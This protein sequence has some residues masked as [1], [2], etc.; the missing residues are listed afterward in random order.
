MKRVTENFAEGQWVIRRNITHG[1][2]EYKTRVGGWTDVPARAWKFDTE[3][4]AKF[5]L[6]GN[7]GEVVQLV[8]HGPQLYQPLPPSRRLSDAER[9]DLADCERLVQAGLEASREARARLLHIRDA[10]LYRQDFATFE[11]YMEKRWGYSA[12][13]G[14]R[15][16]DWSEVEKNLLSEK[17]GADAAE[18][19][20][21]P[22][23][24]RSESQARPLAGLKPAEAQEVWKE[25]VKSAPGGQVTARH[26]QAAVDRHEG[27]TQPSDLKPRSGAWP[28]PNVNGVYSDKLATKLRWS[29]ANVGVCI[30]LLQLGPDQWIQAVESH[31]NCGSMGGHQSPLM[32]KETFPGKPEA[33]LAAVAE[34]TD[35]MTQTIK[36]GVGTK[37]PPQR[38]AARKA[39]VWLRQIGDKAR[40]ETR[41]RCD[42]NGLLDKGTPQVPQTWD[43]VPV[44]GAKAPGD[45]RS[46]EIALAIRNVMAS[47]GG[48]EVL[49]TNNET[50]K[51]AFAVAFVQQARVILRPVLL[52]YAA[53]DNLKA[54]RADTAQ[55]REGP[56]GLK[57]WVICREP[58]D[59]ATCKVAAKPRYAGNPGGWTP[60][61]SKVK[62]FD[63]LQEARARAHTGDHVMELAKAQRRFQH[64]L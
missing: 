14:H 2:V 40:A 21:E 5:I 35:S 42:G 37:T 47:L 34:L 33:T 22:V 3:R 36:G 19:K 44:P 63:N 62:P 52:K 1:R 9:K 23:L 38:A 58:V 13:H 39:L 29:A 41:V 28:T 55:G 45:A 31:F 59:G 61:P 46:K 60:D 48:L 12:R 16:C 24:P 53:M 43:E 26:V 56:K 49:L 51:D 15:L 30:E 4:A 54:A 64:A 17:A 27:K 10:R 7:S 6:R 11:E 32:A 8:D 57:G 50:E 18:S 25:A 20:A